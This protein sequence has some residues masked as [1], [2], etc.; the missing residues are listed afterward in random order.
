MFVD[1]E[2]PKDRPSVGGFDAQRAPAIA[3]RIADGYG[4]TRTRSGADF[5]PIHL[6]AG[7]TVVQFEIR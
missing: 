2:E 4:G 3:G 1:I 5:Q 6:G 7:G